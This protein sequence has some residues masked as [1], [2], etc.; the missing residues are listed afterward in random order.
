M[1]NGGACIRGGVVTRNDMIQYSQ[2][3]IICVYID[4]FPLSNNR[5]PVMTNY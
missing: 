1:K 5:V 3:T 4:N 2:P